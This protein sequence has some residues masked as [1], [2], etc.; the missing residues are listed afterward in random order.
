MNSCQKRNGYVL[1]LLNDVEKK[2]KKKKKRVYFTDGNFHL[3]LHLSLS[4][5]VG[6]NL[7]FM[8]FDFNVKKK[9]E[10]KKVK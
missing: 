5:K 1:N 6:N 10:D 7:S 8:N 9:T 2:K 4:L 3:S